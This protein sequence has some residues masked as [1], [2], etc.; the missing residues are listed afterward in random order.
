LGGGAAGV[1]TVAMF[2]KAFLQVLVLLLPS[3]CCF[4]PLRRISRPALVHLGDPRRIHGV[5]TNDRH[6]QPEQRPLT[7][8]RAP[9]VAVAAGVAATD[10]LGVTAIPP[11]QKQAYAILVLL[12]L[13]TALCALDRVAMSV[14]ILPMSAEFRYSDSE[15]GLIS[16]VFSLGYM[17]GLLPSGLLGTFSSPTVTLSWGVLLWSLAQMSTPFT[18]HISIPVLLVR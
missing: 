15:K 9:S 16:S 14:A 12:F 2:C 18:A 5:E 10:D 17:M 8:L 13:V 3:A 6:E 4:S 1:C 7:L 11:M